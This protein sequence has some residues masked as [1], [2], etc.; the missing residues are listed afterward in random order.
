MA[1]K[2]RST[3]TETVRSAVRKWPTV[4]GTS[5]GDGSLREVFAGTLL[6]HEPSPIDAKRSGLHNE[7]PA[8]ASGTPPSPVPGID[9]YTVP[10]ERGQPIR[11]ILDGQEIEIKSQIHLYAMSIRFL[12]ITRSCRIDHSHL[13]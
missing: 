10:T 1:T 7:T 2:V 4:N 5:P 8:S 9:Y 3:L 13:S 12:V 11:G 6:T